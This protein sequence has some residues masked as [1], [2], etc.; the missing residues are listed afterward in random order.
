MATK[1][2]IE[3]GR[4]HVTLTLDQGPLER[5]L[6]AAKGKF[7][8]WS[9]SLAVMSGAMM[10]VGVAIEAAFGPAVLAFGNYEQAL[11]N[12][13]AAAAPTAE[14]FTRLRSTIERVALAT[15]TSLPET[16]AVFMELVKAGRS[17]DEVVGGLGDAVIRFARVSEMAAAPAAAVLTG[18][19]NIFRQEGLSAV[20]AM[21][22]INQAADS[23]RASLMQVADAF[24]VGGAAAATFDQNMR[25]TVTA[26]ALMAQE[27]IQGADAGTS[28]RRILVNL[29][30]GGGNEEGGRVVAAL[31]EIGLGLESFRGADGRMLPMVEMIGRLNTAMASLGPAARQMAI[32]NIGG[33]YGMTGL[34]ALLKHGAAGW[35]EMQRKMGGALTVEQKFAILTET[36]LEGLKKLWV[37]IQLVAV[38]IGESLA[39]SM[40][41]TGAIA[42]PLLHALAKFI[43]AN[44]RIVQ[45]VDTA[46]IA[47]IAGGAALGVLGVAM[48]SVGA[49]IG[50]VVKLWYVALGVVKL[51]TLGIGVQAV[52]IALY[53][54]VI[55][56][57]AFA[58]KVLSIAYGI[59]TGAGFLFAVA[60]AAPLIGLGLMTGAIAAVVAAIPV[61]AAGLWS[62]IRGVGA[63]FAN[64]G[65]SI[66]EM[67][68]GIGA[69][70]ATMLAGMRDAIA[71]GEMELAFQIVM[72]GLNVVWL[73]TLV[74]LRQTWADVVGALRFIWESMTTWMA[75]TMVNVMGGFAVVCENIFQGVRVAWSHMVEW[76]AI[77]LSAA[78][79]LM[80]EMWI[81]AREAVNPI[82]STTRTDRL[83]REAR[84]RGAGRVE[85]IE[86]AGTAE[87]ERIELDR[88][89]R[90]VN[91]AANVRRLQE[92]ID[93][94]RNV[95]V[96]DPGLA[97]LRD[98]LR[99]AQ[100][101]LE[102][103]R[104]QAAT[105]AGG[106][107]AGGVAGAIMALG[108]N[109]RRPQGP[110]DRAMSSA[111]G[112]TFSGSFFR[113]AF[114][115]M[116]GV[117]RSP[118][119]VTNQRLQTLIELER[120]M[121]QAIR[122]IQ[123][124]GF[125]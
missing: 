96:D 93:D 78:L 110:G 109:L 103:L 22:L 101:E 86:L 56:G 36:F 61:M 44:Q 111:I 69:T 90:M 25:D 18:A 45:I 72:A 6:N 55:L 51:L 65:S 79:S 37:G 23:S 122:D 17:V 102:M 53:K 46:A 26:I 1:G 28:L 68:T 115:G 125:A 107:I 38:A 5:G 88:L 81:R 64:V 71:A 92:Q 89:Q 120:Q 19:M 105:A 7:Q 62:A 83:V 3:A 4:A 124:L 114:R 52:A 91:I 35:G 49:V 9:K 12:L 118:V 24:T 67:F 11:A 50:V 73:Q 97:A 117:T 87:R 32:T 57:A 104:T 34:T 121:I 39:P 2:S 59:A 27:Q 14:E 16:T 30:T 58:L 40:K 8:A 15:G 29:G 108:M 80:E 95:A 116:G 13:R 100:A 113:D 94:A 63:A 70:F 54:L 74:G 98:R 20:Q 77:R 33:M 85:S 75:R 48:W 84:L 76:M 99:V 66:G 60:V 10:G 21:N 43:H 41:I 106:G 112:T 42:L 119:E 47:L 123:G 31:Q 82:G